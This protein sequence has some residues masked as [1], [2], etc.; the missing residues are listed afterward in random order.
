MAYKILRITN[1]KKG[2]DVH[3]DL[4]F[5]KKTLYF[6]SQKVFD[7]EFANRMAQAELNVQHDLDREAYDAEHPTFYSREDVKKLLIARNMIRENQTVEDLPTKSAFLSRL[8]DYE[9]SEARILWNK[10]FGTSW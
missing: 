4:G 1:L 6:E 2:F 9:R 7:A 8:T 5:R 10:I 3:V